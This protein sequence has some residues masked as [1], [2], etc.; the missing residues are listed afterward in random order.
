MKDTLSIFITIIIFVTLIVIFP[1]YNYFDRQNDMSYNMALKATTDFVN[2]VIYCG[3]ISQEKYDDYVDK[4]ANTGNLYDIELE[5]QRRIMIDD[6]SDY[7]AQYYNDYTEDIFDSSEGSTK[8]NITDSNLLKRVIKSGTYKLNVGDKVFVKIQNSGTNMAEAMIHMFAPLADKKSITINYGGIVKNNTW[9]EANVPLI[10]GEILKDDGSSITRDASGLVENRV[11]VVFMNEG[12]IYA[13]KTF[14][15]GG[16]YGDDLPSAP[17][18][19]GYDFVGWNKKSDGSGTTIHEPSTVPDTDHT[20][21]AIFKD[22]IPPQVG[23][24]HIKVFNTSGF[25]TYEDIGNEFE[26]TEE[27]NGRVKITFENGSDSQSGHER[28]YLDIY[29]PGT[30]GITRNIQTDTNNIEYNTPGSY[31]VKLVTIDK[32]GNRS[33]TG[34]VKFV[35]KE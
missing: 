10:K 8:E 14:T 11:N 33:E 3:Y 25:V 31:N 16:V 2:D 1:L 12:N 29:Y 32:A 27:F 6:S 21:Y 24:L 30:G 15:K 20:L 22:N 17:E 19:A 28:T 9:L 35:I 26:I 4:L 18:K 5:A 13:Q 23:T 34:E 7:D